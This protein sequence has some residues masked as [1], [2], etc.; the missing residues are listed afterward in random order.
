MPATSLVRRAGRRRGGA[1]HLGPAPICRR[2]WLGALPVRSEGLPSRRSR[3][4]EKRLCGVNTQD[5]SI[6]DHAR[7]RSPTTD[8][9]PLPAVRG[10]PLIAA[11]TTTSGYLRGSLSYEAKDG[12]IVQLAIVV[13][14][15]RADKIGLASPASGGPRLCRPRTLER[16]AK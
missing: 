14:W 13:D 7:P 9:S 16:L 1:A 11:E 8:R 6:I 4:T 10:A 12:S 15:P 3:P 2:G 5:P